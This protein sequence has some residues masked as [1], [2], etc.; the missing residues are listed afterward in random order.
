MAS[1]VVSPES[2]T[3]QIS[4][5]DWLLVKKRLNHGEY[6]ELLARKYIA[7]TSGGVRVN[8]HK[9]GWEQ[10]AVYL[11]NWSLTGLDGKQIAIDGKSYDAID[12]ELDLLD[13]ASVTEI[14]Q[15]IETHIAEMEAERDASKKILDGATGSSATSPSLSAVAGATS[16]SAH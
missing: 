4:S 8:L 9:A 6:Q 7:E 1:R 14:K 15:A 12:R 16:G 5:G 10:I 3:L 2:T 13:P 11:L